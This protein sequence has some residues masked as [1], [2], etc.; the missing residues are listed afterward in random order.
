MSRYHENN[1]ICTF[2]SHLGSWV[3]TNPKT[4][5]AAAVVEHLRERLGSKLPRLLMKPNCCWSRNTSSSWF[6]FLTNKWLPGVSRRVDASLVSGPLL[7]ACFYCCSP[8]YAL[9]QSLLVVFSCRKVK[10]FHSLC[11]SLY[12]F[13]RLGLSFV[14]VLLQVGGKWQ[15][16]NT[17]HGS[18]VAVFTVLKHLILKLINKNK[19]CND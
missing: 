9:S 16:K 17:F 8:P 10:L 2:S 13:T 18:I 3:S 5:R 11:V 6:C 4:R 19:A 14:W 7:R 1:W 15:V 12:I